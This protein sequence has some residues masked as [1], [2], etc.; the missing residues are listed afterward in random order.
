MH[1]W[2][3]HCRDDKGKGIVGFADHVIN[4]DIHSWIAREAI[5]DYVKALLNAKKGIET[6]SDLS[7]DDKRVQRILSRMPLH[8]IDATRECLSI[9]ERIE[10]P[11]AKM[12][13]FQ[14]LLNPKES[15]YTI[16]QFYKALPTYLR[17]KFKEHMRVANRGEG[18]R[19]GSQ[20]LCI[21]AENP[22][23]PLSLKAVKS[24]IAHLHTL[25]KFG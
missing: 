3:V 14:A 19:E 16:T 7:K 9:F 4:T 10:G 18:S 21:F 2:R 1:I 11:I 17:E 22:Y 5:H 8:S 13:V 23:G 6:H 24:V 12:T 25:E 15:S 20:E